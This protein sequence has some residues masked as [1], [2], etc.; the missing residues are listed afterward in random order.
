VVFQ[1]R[2]REPTA[3]GLNNA[4]TWNITVRNAGVLGWIDPFFPCAKKFTGGVDVD[5]FYR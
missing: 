5:H 2:P 3:A 1:W 4:N